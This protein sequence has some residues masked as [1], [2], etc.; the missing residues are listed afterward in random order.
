VGPMTFFKLIFFCR[1]VIQT[2]FL[3]G[4]KSK[5]AQ[6]TGTEIIFKPYLNSNVVDY[7][8]FIPTV[9]FSGVTGTGFFQH[10]I[11]VEPGEV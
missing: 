3:Q 1:D 11:T 8:I 4:R 5:H 9:H 6:I 7:L 2:F 10:L